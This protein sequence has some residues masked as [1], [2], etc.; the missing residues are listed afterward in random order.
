MERRFMKKLRMRGYDISRVAGRSRSLFIASA[1]SAVL[2]FVPS[3]SKSAPH[4]EVPPPAVGNEAPSF[5][6][7]DVT[8]QTVS[9]SDFRGKVVVM[10]FWA[11]WC[12]PC[13]ETTQELN[14]LYSRYKDAD[15][16]I[17]GVNMDGSGSAAKKVEDFAGKY[18]L[19][20]PMLIDDGTASKA[21]YVN[22]IPTTFVLDKEHVILKIY[23]GYLPGLGRMI[24][25]EIATQR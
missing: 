1:I 17:L 8:G 20:Y 4:K 7:K 25:E 22:K 9:L 16:V 6:L 2:F 24:A 10:D 14:R 5:T 23:P 19:A 21:Y 3:C 11:T 13:R 12:L 18:N 15:V